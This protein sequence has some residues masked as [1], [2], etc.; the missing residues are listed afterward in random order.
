MYKRL[1]FKFLITVLIFFLVSAIFSFLVFIQV[2][3][4]ESLIVSNE[5]R[6]KNDSIFYEV[7]SVNDGDTILLKSG[8]AVRYL[9]IDTPETHHPTIGEECGGKE[10]TDF[11][12]RL[13]EGKRVRLLKDIS[14]TDHYGRLLRYVFTE[15]GLFVNYEL[16]R[17]GLAQPLI[18]GEDILFEETFYDAQVSAKKDNLGIWRDCI[19][20]G[21]DDANEVEK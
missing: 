6:D 12:K 11:N 3:R 19:G 14:E 5:S 21:G 15:D 4:K 8:E 18:M 9:G 2:S 7:Q 10:A 1:N 17:N 20:K 16:V 13:L